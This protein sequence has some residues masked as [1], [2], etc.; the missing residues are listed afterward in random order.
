MKGLLLKEFY[1]W[2]KSRSY[3]LALVLIYGILFT[4]TDSSRSAFYIIWM[5]LITLSKAFA[6]D[7]TNNWK[8]YSHA[9]PYTP[10]QI[11][12]ARYLF[13]FTETAVA[14]IVATISII[15]SFLNSETIDYGKYFPYLSNEWIIA[16][17]TTLIITVLFLGLALSMPVNYKFTGTVRN[18]ISTIPLIIAM[19][20]IIIISVKIIISIA[21][22]DGKIPELFYNERWL[23]AACAAVALLALAASWILC[24]I[25][26]AKNK[27]RTKKLKMIAA[28]LIA[29]AVVISAVSVGIIYK[30]G[31]FD[32]EELTYED[33]KDMQINNNSALE[34]SL[35]N[36]KNEHI[37]V[38]KEQKACRKEMKRLMESFLSENHL[39]LNRQELEEIILDMGYFDTLYGI[40]EYTHI[41]TSDESS[42]NTNCVTIRFYTSQDSDAITVVDISAEVGQF[43]IETATTAELDEIG[44]KFTEGMTQ[45]ELHDTFESLDIVPRFIKESYN[46]ND[47]RNI[48]Y[49]VSYT[50][51]DYNGEGGIEY[52][53]NIDVSNGI[54]T[55]VRLY[56]K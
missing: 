39:N 18:I 52:R 8:N 23:F 28:V 48:Y 53:I 21:I 43:Y 26:T 5:G 37:S 12:S 38:S 19:F 7:E 2:L 40:T 36:E 47:E 14:A 4:V 10:A 55:S 22:P 42:R 34:E 3:W 33:Y 35:M 50:I 11:V 31:Y 56:D 17:N 9:L 44:S 46:E 25:F 13:L 6:D 54:V 45:A 27:S 30:N 15:I 1:T 41:D 29:I 20:I 49:L 24:I 32:K 51:G 16:S